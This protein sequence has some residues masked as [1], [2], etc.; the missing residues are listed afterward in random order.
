MTTLAPG[1]STTC[2]ATTRLRRHPGRRR[3]RRRV[4]HRDGRRPTT[5]GWPGRPSPSSTDT[6]SQQVPGLHLTKSAIAADVDGDGHIDLGDRI[7]WT[8]LVSNTGTVTVHSVAVDDPT[9][10]AVAAPR[11]RWRPGASTTCTAADHT[12]TQADV[13]AGVVDN[14][15]TASALTA[16]RR[17]GDLQPVL[18]RRPRSPRPRPCSS[19]S[20]RRSRTSTATARP[21]AATPSAGR[22]SSPTRARRRSTQLRSTTRRPAR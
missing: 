13:D 10:G 17:D 4:Q 20:R 7:T 8:F 2:T 19:P 22:S 15:A 6:A 3:R 14:T 21:T 18:D 11:R 16:E 12:V 9:A 5:R 1:A